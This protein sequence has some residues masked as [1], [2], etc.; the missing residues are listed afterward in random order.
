MTARLR[1]MSLLV[2][3]VF[4]ERQR[5]LPLSIEDRLSR[6]DFQLVKPAFC[7]LPTSGGPFALVSGCT[8]SQVL[9]ER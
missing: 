7:P 9:D 8:S 2:K 3:L 6:E 1:R 5:W 4:E